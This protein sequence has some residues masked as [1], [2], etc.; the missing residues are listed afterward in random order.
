LSHDYR[1]D[2]G[3]LR[4]LTDVSLEIPPGGYCSIQGRSGAG[5]TTLLSLVGGLERP[6]AGELRVGGFDLTRLRGDD[7]AAYRRSTVGFVFQH[8][9]LLASLTAL[10]NVELAATLAAEPARRRR[11]RAH[12][13]LRAVGLGERAGHVP[14]RLS[15]GEQQR[16]AMARALVNRPRLLLADEPTG[17]LDQESGEHVLRLLEELH[18]EWGFTLVVVTHNVALA[19]RADQ[20]FVVEAGVVEE[21]VQPLA[22]A[23]GPPR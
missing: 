10:E 18:R 19:G 20:R 2:R 16:V 7:L 3:V 23:E 9:G 17:N 1:G 8:F 21:V 5:K 15:G 12:E 22:A 11:R 6:Q 13:L 4:V 14:A